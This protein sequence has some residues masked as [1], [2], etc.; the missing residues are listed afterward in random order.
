M[1]MKYNYYQSIG[2]HAIRVDCHFLFDSSCEMVKI[3]WKFLLFNLSPF[4]CSVYTLTCCYMNIN[5]RCCFDLWMHIVIYLPFLCRENKGLW[6]TRWWKTKEAP[7]LL[8]RPVLL[9]LHLNVIRLIFLYPQRFALRTPAAFPLHV[10]IFCWKRKLSLRL[11]VFFLRNMQFQW[12][13]SILTRVHSLNKACS[14]CME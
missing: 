11:F 14:Q 5:H 1:N 10:H 4:R 2:H 9:L 12:W 7:A 3:S 8:T 6:W 13:L